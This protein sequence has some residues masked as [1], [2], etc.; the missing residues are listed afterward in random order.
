MSPEELLAVMVSGVNPDGTPF[1]LPVRIEDGFSAQTMGVQKTNAGFL[2][3][4]QTAKQYV[5]RNQATS[6]TVV[7]TVPLE[8]VTGPQSAQVQITGTGATGGEFHVAYTVGGVSY[9]TQAIPYNSA[10]AAVA[11]A[12]QNSTPAP[13][14]AAFAGSGGP[15]PGTAVA[16][17][18]QGALAGL[19]VTGTSITSEPQAPITGVLPT[20]ASTVTGTPG[21]TFYITDIFLTSDAAQ[22]NNCEAR[23]QAAGTDI[24]AGSVH[25][26]SSINMAGIET[27]PFATSGQVV[28]LVL[29]AT[30]A[31]IAHVWAF[32]SGFEQ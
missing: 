23:I 27:Q 18:F 26:L 8:T 30:T 16:I 32:V 4:G 28:N 17:T 7:T 3:V 5:V 9:T 2:A 20:I 15:L 25:A 12:F 6:T 1:V 21:K 29:S 31:G 14:A 22:T 13:P 11:T 10:A 19:P 24:F